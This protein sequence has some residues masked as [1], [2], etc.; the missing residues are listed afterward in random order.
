[1]T[2]HPQD[3]EYA[4]A[5][6]KS[7][8]GLHLPISKQPTAKHFLSG[9]C[10]HNEVSRTACAS[11]HLRAQEHLPAEGGPEAETK[12]AETKPSFLKLSPKCK[13]NQQSQPH[14]QLIHL[15]YAFPVSVH[16]YYDAPTPPTSYIH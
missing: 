9:N 14:R 3:Y 10:S 16:S 4:T 7:N 12:D 15:D 5:P 8:W 6:H 1:M 2:K 11:L 13:P